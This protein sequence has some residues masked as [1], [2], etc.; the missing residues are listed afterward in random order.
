MDVVKFS[1]DPCAYFRFKARFYE[2]IDYQSISEVQKMS[3]LY[4][5]QLLDDQA[6]RA[7]AGFEGVS[8]GLSKG[9]IMIE[10]CLRL[11]QV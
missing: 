6:K 10:Q 7:V 5:L 11:Y 1:G 2:M 9:L 8:G 4:I 3:R